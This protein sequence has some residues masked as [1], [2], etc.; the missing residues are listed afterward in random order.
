MHESGSS[1]PINYNLTRSLYNDHR[2]TTAFNSFLERAL[3]FRFS[4]CTDH[5]FARRSITLSP[6][7]SPWNAIW[8]SSGDSFSLR[9]TK[10]ESP[11]EGLPGECSFAS[12]RLQNTRGDST[13]SCIPSFPCSRVP[14]SKRRS[15]D[16]F[17]SPPSYVL[18][19][20]KRLYPLQHRPRIFRYPARIAG[21]RI[22][23][24]VISIAQSSVNYASARYNV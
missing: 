2:S 12:P 6:F 5:R 4:N 7:E 9:A 17:V 3:L 8:E 1:V 23:G 13:R 18:G 22:S 24:R 16:E 19:E 10:E 14:R 20:E 21:S 15:A 11:D